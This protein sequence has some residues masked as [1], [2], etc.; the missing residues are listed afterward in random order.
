MPTT[1]YGAEAISLTRQLIECQSVTPNDA[2]CQEILMQRLMT[3]GF[4]CE[5]M[6]FGDVDNFW[7]SRGQGDGT[8]VFAG[9]TDVVPTGPEARWST[10]P[11]TPTERDGV[12][13]G[14]GTADMK[15]SLAAMTVAA[16][17]FTKQHGNHIGRL[18]FLITA[19]EEGPATDGTVKVVEELISRG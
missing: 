3:A 1:E 14:R 10:E 8:L 5:S 19:D 7:A 6:R 17:A 12:L 16:E 13:Y 11:F 15:A 4:A 9:H 2:G 18:A